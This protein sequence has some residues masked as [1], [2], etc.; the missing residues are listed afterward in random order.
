MNHYT[1]FRA[2]QLPN[3]GSSFS[4]R[5]DNHFTLIEARYN[6]LNKEHIKWELGLL[7]RSDIDAL[8]ITSW[9]DDHCNYS[10]LQTILRFLRPKR[11]EYPSET[12]TTMNGMRAL[13]AIENYDKLHPNV[14]VVRNHPLKCIL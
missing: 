12:P 6:E 5:V 11:I 2:Y 1:R 10:E 13:V 3:K 4:L 8:H 7:R 14:R 9:D